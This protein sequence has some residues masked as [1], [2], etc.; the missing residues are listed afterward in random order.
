MDRCRV[1]DRRHH[2]RGWNPG[3]QQQCRWRE[4]LKGFAVRESG[5][6]ADTTCTDVLAVEHVIGQIALADQNAY[7][8]LAAPGIQRASGT[9]RPPT[10]GGNVRTPSTGL[11]KWER[12]KARKAGRVRAARGEA[13]T[14]RRRTTDWPCPRS[15][16][17]R[18][19]RRVWASPLRR[20]R[21][22]LRAPHRAAIDLREAS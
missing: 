18:C 7:C 13:R 1:S 16:P 15:G 6:P 9:G 4:D 20:S 14:R 8:A 22:N 5:L 10:T 11:R 17:S 3:R 21:A 12:S 2:C 19:G